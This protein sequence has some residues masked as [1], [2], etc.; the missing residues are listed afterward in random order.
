[1]KLNVRTGVPILYPRMVFLETV[2]SS[3]FFP[4]VALKKLGC[5]RIAE[6]NKFNG[7]AELLDDLVRSIFFFSR[8]RSE[9]IVV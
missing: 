2:L 3:K 5:G 7:E 8:Q 1:M 9:L 6:K 4:S